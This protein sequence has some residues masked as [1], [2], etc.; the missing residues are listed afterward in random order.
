MLIYSNENDNANRFKVRI[1]YLSKL[2]FRIIMSSSMEELLWP[3]QPINSDIK[4]YEEIKM[5]T[6][7]KGGDYTT[8]CALD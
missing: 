6:T 7:G 1:Y 8:G 5:L 4:W 2:L 3:D